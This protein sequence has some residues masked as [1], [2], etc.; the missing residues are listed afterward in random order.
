MLSWEYLI[1]ARVV[2]IVLVEISGMSSGLTV[3]SAKISDGFMIL[4]VF[5]IALGHRLVSSIGA[6]DKYNQLLKP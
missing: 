6:T 3:R 1:L 4:G 2:L 5:T